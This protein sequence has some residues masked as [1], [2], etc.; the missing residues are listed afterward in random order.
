M[1]TA[2]DAAARGDAKKALELIDTQA[3][4]AI[5]EGLRLAD[6]APLKTE[7]AKA[8][9]DEVANVLR[10]RKT[11]LPRYTEA[12]KSGDTEKMI[13]AMEAQATIERHALAAVAAIDAER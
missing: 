2:D 12:V 5:D 9:R 6:S 7:W 1:H 10:E 11:E 13:A 8:K 3:K 4:P